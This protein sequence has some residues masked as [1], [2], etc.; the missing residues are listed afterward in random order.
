VV[1]MPPALVQIAAFIG[2]RMGTTI[3]DTALAQL[4]HGNT[5]DYETFAR[6]TGIEAIGWKRALSTHPAQQQ[7][8][9][10]ARLYFVGPLLRYALAILW[11]ASGITGLLDLRG[12]G[13]LL[14][15][16]LPIGMG[17]ALFGLAVACVTDLLVAVL[18]V[19]RWRP[20]RL[21][22]I[23]L[24]LVVGYTA[25]ATA[26]FPSLWLEPLGPLLKNLPILAAI[27][28]WASIEDES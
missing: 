11:L 9:W 15:S 19:R 6:Q 5:G 27:L 24:A 23:Q 10:H 3:N 4:R 13:V 17:T 7:D 21:A 18:L 28:A 16:R 26:L 20:R 14:I 2:T 8:R 22:L 1:S 12:W 25:A